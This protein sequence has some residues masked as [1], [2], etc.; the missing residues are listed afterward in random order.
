MK[1]AI[2]CQ[3]WDRMLPSQGSLTT[4]IGI[5][6]REAALRIPKTHS[7]TF[8]SAADKYTLHTV[9]EQDD[10]FS[11]RA[12]PGSSIEN[13]LSLPFKV[14]Y[15]R[16]SARGNRHRPFFATPYYYWFYARRLAS[17]L[18]QQQFDLIYVMNF[19][20]FIPIIRA[21]NPHS[22]IVLNM[23]CDW[24]GQIDA[25]LVRPALEQT[26]LVVGCATH[27]VENAT[28]RFPE[29]ANRFV[30]VSNG[31][32]LK[33]FNQ[34]GSAG[35]A[36]LSRTPDAPR[37]ILFV[38]RVSPEKGV[39]VAIEA[40]KKVR[41]RIDNVVLDI[42]GPL[43]SAPPEFLIKLDR[44]PRVADLMKYYGEDG[45]QDR[46][47]DELQAMIPPELKSSII[48]HGTVR[49]EALADYYR[50]ADIYINSSLS[51]AFPLPIGEA[52]ACGAPVVAARVGGIPDMV[53]H[54]ETGLLFEIDRADQLADALVDMLS[55]DT[56]RAAFGQRGRQHILTHFTW[57]HIG[58]QL[59]TEFDRLVAQP[60][61]P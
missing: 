17:D 41:Q 10:R 4:S 27:V 36:P 22:K 55:D 24:L 37:R 21:Q 59:V 39:H 11:Y 31:V 48:F 2:V 7:V 38:G 29:L 56:R 47:Y 5:L 26:D 13:R 33:D 30:K 15:E 1:I 9:I 14:A 54:G 32:N 40:F 18:R 58:Q 19:F 3:P 45:K 20:Q 34:A 46:Y 44:D 16:L 25:D 12:I 61:H 49:H 52:M 57:D 42:A 43:G 35:K 53:I 28:H 50:N 51:E 60:G 23:N 8:Y 6:A